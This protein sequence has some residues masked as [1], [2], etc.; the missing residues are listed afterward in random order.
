MIINSGHLQPTDPHST[1]RLA[2]RGEDV[3][4]PRSGGVVLENRKSGTAVVISNAILI[5]IGEHV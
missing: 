1:E 2:L 4:P 3:E 5:V